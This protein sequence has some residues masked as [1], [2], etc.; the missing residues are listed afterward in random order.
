MGS[1]KDRLGDFAGRP[2]GFLPITAG[3]LDPTKD[4]S[5]MMSLVGGHIPVSVP[6]KA[7]EPF[8][9]ITTD[10]SPQLGLFELADEGTD[11]SGA[12]TA[13]TRFLDSMDSSQREQAVFG[14]DAVQWRLWTNG[15]AM[16]DTYGLCLE[17]LGRAQRNAAMAMIEQ[18]LSAYGYTTTRNVMKLNAALGEMLGEYR[19]TLTE[20]M[21]YVAVFGTPGKNEPWGWQLWGHHLDISCFVLG[22]QLVLTPVFMGAEPAFADSGTFAGV[23]ALEAERTA[24]FAMFDA[25]SPVQRRTATLYPSILTKDLPHEINSV[26]DGRHLAGAGQDNRIIGFEGIPGSELTAGQREAL[27]GVTA[28]YLDRLPGGSREAKQAAVEKHLDNT[29]FSWIGGDDPDGANYYR[30]HSPVLLI[31][32]DN[33]PGIFLDNPEPEPFHIHTIVRTP[34]GNDYGKDLLRQH[35]QQHHHSEAPGHAH[36]HG[37]GHSHAHGDGHEHSHGEPPA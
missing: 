28:P 33:H 23:S 4:M 21:Y 30:V 3:A 25:L 16:G 14:I 36:A 20:W 17:R 12:V 34:N 13:A 7:Q 11:T 5:G 10:G 15:F 8:V 24:G 32:Y 6:E 1:Y 31:E 27:L 19:D 37:P 29:W 2:P 22:N 18:S 26:F 9:G 35:Y